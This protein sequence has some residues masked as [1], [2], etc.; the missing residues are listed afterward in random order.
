MKSNIN[1][2]MVSSVFKT[3]CFMTTSCTNHPLSWLC[4]KSIFIVIIEK[5][6]LLFRTVITEIQTV[7]PMCFIGNIFQTN[8][9]HIHNVCGHHCLFQSEVYKSF[10][11]LGP[12]KYL[13]PQDLSSLFN[14]PLCYLW[15]LNTVIQ[16]LWGSTSLAY[17]VLNMTY[18]RVALI[19]QQRQDKNISFI[20]SKGLQGLKKGQ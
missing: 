8:N 19:L 17:N 2:I 4:L 10:P 11:S 20:Q 12:S 5:Y 7:F 16:H 14:I 18:L 3:F 9:T 15:M 13:N 1:T 6:M